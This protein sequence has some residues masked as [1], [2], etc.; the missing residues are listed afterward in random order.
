MPVVL[1]WQGYRELRV[2]CKLYS[3]DLGVNCILEIDGILNMPQALNIP[4][5]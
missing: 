4:K 3:R 5:F 2:L 1:K